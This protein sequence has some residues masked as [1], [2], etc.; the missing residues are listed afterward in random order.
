MR[1]MS[2]LCNVFFMVLDLK[3]VKGGRRDDGHFFLPLLTIEADDEISKE[4]DIFFR[5]AD[6]QSFAHIERTYVLK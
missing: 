3:F 4:R 1:K 5:D 2:Y 6:S